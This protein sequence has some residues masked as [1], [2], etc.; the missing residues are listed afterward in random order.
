MGI[1]VR[2]VGA[3]VL[4]MTAA[5]AQ[6][7]ENRFNRPGAFAGLG[8]VYAV[9]AFQGP[10]GHLFGDSLGFQARGGYRF[11]EIFAA[12][13]IYEYVD[14][15]GLRGGRGGFWTNNMTANGKL[16]LPLD[17][18]QPYLS[19]GIG[20]LNIVPHGEGDAQWTFAGRFGG[21]TDVAITEHVALFLDASYVVPAGGGAISNIQYFSFGWGGKYLF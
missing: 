6:A 10:A 9:S 5:A 19:G 14:D 1:A 15:F 4:V 8:G 16:I 18:F 12:E 20:F 7:E 13:G 21:G 17:R 3:C 11:N 2:I